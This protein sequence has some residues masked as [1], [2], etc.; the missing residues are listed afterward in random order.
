MQHVMQVAQQRIDV[1]LNA[2]ARVV[3]CGIAGLPQPRSALSA[4]LPHDAIHIHTAQRAVVQGQ[5]RV[6]KMKIVRRLRVA[7]CRI[8]SKGRH[9][10]LLLRFFCQR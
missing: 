3:R 6:P 9:L 1:A 10:A 7:A 5:G 2:R 4:H 8:D